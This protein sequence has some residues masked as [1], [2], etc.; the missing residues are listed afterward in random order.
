MPHW[1]THMRNTIATFFDVIA[2]RRARTIRTQKR[3]QADIPLTPAVHRLLGMDITTI[4]DYRD[5]AVQDLIRSL[6]Y[7][8]SRH[9]ARLCAQVLVDFLMEELSEEKAYSPRRILLVPMPLHASRLRERGFNQIDIVLDHLPIEWR[10]GSTAAIAPHALIRIKQTRSQA[11]LSRAD[12]I[13]N[14]QDAFTVPAPDTI[15]DTHIYLLDDVTTTGA[16]LKSAAH[17]LRAAGAKVTPLALAR[18]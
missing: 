16:T 7:D 3:A 1:Y 15:R 9:A 8:G 6:K 12:R 10:N 2:P 14:M 4:M 17:A 13:K 11:H 5:T 18:A